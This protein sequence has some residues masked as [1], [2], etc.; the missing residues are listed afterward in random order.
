MIALRCAR[1][2]DGDTMHH[3]PRTVVLDGGRIVDAATDITEVV[4]L[5]DVTLLPGLVDAHTHLAFQ[6]GSDIPRD[7][8]ESPR[9]VV[10]ERM[11][12]HA[13]Q[14]LRAGIT[15][16]RDLGDREYL[17]VALRDGGGV[18]PEILAAGPPI[19]TPGGHCWFLGGEVPPEPA[20]L[21]DAVAERAARGVNVIKVMATGGNITPGCAAHESQYDREQLRVIV[22]AA[23]AAGLPVT[24][25]AH[26]GGGI[27]DAVRAGVDGIEHGTFLTADG[28]APDWDTIREIIA[29]GTYV[30]ITAGRLL[31]GPPPPARVLAA[32]AF[33]AQMHREGARLVCSSDAGIIGYKPHYCLPHGLT[34]FQG[35][36]GASAAETLT[37][38]TRLA[39][40]SCAVGDRKGRI[41][42]GYD[43][44]LL[45]VWGDPTEDLAAMRDVAAVFRAGERVSL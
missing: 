5:G 26:G 14:A 27:R 38:V 7:M 16:L 23:H 2:F 39:A 25:H 24:A 19:T 37:A 13:V 43:A 41:A 3:G 21:A 35:F 36:I 18:L 34:D 20:A 6:P 10:L 33:L 11:R 4:D 22:D 8:A 9:E 42:A 28:S 17:A 32:R 12:T 29:A 40:E 45:A 31:T 44:D 15:T 30:G 1:L